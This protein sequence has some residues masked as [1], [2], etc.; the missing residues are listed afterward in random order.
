MSSQWKRRMFAAQK[1][2]Q[3]Q[4]NVLTASLVGATDPDPTTTIGSNIATPI[5]NHANPTKVAKTVTKTATKTA[6]KTTKSNQT[7][8]KP[9]II[10]LTEDYKLAVCSASYLG[11]K[12]YT[13]PMSVLTPDDL[14]FLHTDLFVKPLAMGPQYGPAGGADEAAFP[15]YRE[16]TKKIYIPRFYGI[17]RYGLPPKSEISPGENIDVPFAKPLR[18]YQDHIIDV[19][20]RHVNRPISSAT[21]TNDGAL[22]SGGILEVPCGRGKCLGK[23]TPILMFDGSIKMVQ[24]IVV[25]DVLMGDD[26]GPRTVLSLARGQEM[27]YKVIDNQRKKG[28][29]GENPN[30]IVNESH[31]LSLKDINT[32]TVVD[33]PILDYLDYLHNNEENA[34][35]FP[36]QLLMG[37]RVPVEFQEQPVKID[38][39]LLGI[40][41]TSTVP[42]E[43]ELHGGGGN[44]SI[45]QSHYQHSSLITIDDPKILKYVTDCFVAKHPS[46][47]LQYLGQNEYQIQSLN[48]NNHMFREFLYKNQL[49]FDQHIPKQYSRNSRKIRLEVL[50]GILDVQGEVKY[51]DMEYFAINGFDQFNARLRNDIVFLARSLGF[52]VKFSDDLEIMKIFGPIEL[53]S[54]IPVKTLRNQLP[55]VVKMEVDTD[56]STSEITLDFTDL[57]YSSHLTYP[58][59]I[60]PIGV[61]D[62]YGFEIDGNRR[63]VLGDLTVTHNT[64]MALKII[65]LLKKKTLI[66]VHKEFLMNQWIERAQEFLPTAKVGRIQ[67]PVF[68]VKGKDI[69]L[70]MLQ[71][72]YDRE[73]P[74]GAFD[75]FGLTI[76]DEVHRIGSEQFSKTLLRTITPNMLGISATVDRKDK[77]TKIL[78]MFMGNKI[79]TESRKD[80]DLVCVR[81]VEYI[82]SDPE[83]NETAYDFRGNPKFST[84]ISKLCD[85]GPRSDFIVRVLGDLVKEN[86]ECQIMVLCHNRS[87]LKYFYEAIQHRGI[88]S[89]G[90]Y[91]GGMKQVDLQ[92]TEEKQIVLATYA[93]AAEALDIKTLSV[94]VMATP[95]T[96]IIQSVGRILRVR[97]DNPIVVDIVDRH[98]IFQNQW[99]KRKTFYRKC[100]YRIRSMDSVRYGGMSF[101]WNADKTWNKVFEP[102]VNKITNSSST[103]NCS[104]GEGDQGNDSNDVDNPLRQNKCLIALDTLDLEDLE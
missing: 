100:N 102:R 13:I 83:F 85:F 35:G 101:D 5:V 3:V 61:D 94:L 93:M 44:G 42:F 48:R 37:Y 6:T 41:L 99:A 54:T 20:M 66:I 36:L 81:A 67:G 82:S 11:K 34:S 24:N 31:I 56:G 69:V 45:M 75:Q 80:E 28:V 74:D 15:V 92:E 79:Y 22:G 12:G 16:N 96:D 58:I 77:L 72:L 68:D 90:Y 91:V 4:E 57:T 21:D 19:Y 33:M 98:E 49:P 50:A 64:V 26:S 27:M 7:L 59:K 25:G 52:S 38:P 89:V 39:Y 30:Y 29:K 73:F 9:L 95:K 84:M 32:D 76:V 51:N 2:K 55:P 8:A 103:I 86:G 60:E 10:P 43:H 104:S 88:C 87:L 46:L 18:D 40:W 53:L 97:H 47:C 78:Y 1:A 63:F 62:Y 65:S 17:S 14:D 70:G 23:D 71:T